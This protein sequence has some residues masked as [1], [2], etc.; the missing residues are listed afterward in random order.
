MSRRGTQ[1]VTALLGLIM[2]LLLGMG[3]MSQ[4]LNRLL[5]ERPAVAECLK[6]GGTA[7]QCRDASGVAAGHAAAPSP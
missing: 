5:E 2:L 6:A 7:G 1:V 3:A 4:R